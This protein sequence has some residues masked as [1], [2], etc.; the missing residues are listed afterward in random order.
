LHRRL[1]AAEE[2]VAVQPRREVKPLP[3]V[4]VT[5]LQAAPQRRL[6]PQQALLRAPRLVPELE[7]RQQAP[8]RFHRPPAQ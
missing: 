7:V 5:R 3:P 2:E 6:H 8:A 1:V 4:A